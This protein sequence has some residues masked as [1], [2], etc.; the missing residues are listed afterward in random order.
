MAEG[1]E[2]ILAIGQTTGS[3]ALLVASTA[4]SS[5]T[6]SIPLSAMLAKIL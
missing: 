6:D 1:L 4:F 5:V 3:A 2:H